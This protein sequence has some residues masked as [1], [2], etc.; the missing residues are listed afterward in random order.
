MYRKFLQVS[1]NWEN[2]EIVKKC[3]NQIVQE[4]REL[5][6]IVLTMEETEREELF[7]R[8]SKMERSRIINLA[9]KH[10]AQMMDLIHRYE[11]TENG[12]QRFIESLFKDVKLS[13]LTAFENVYRNMSKHSEIF[14][15]HLQ[16]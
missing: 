5:E 12:K 16:V 13:M 6:D 2:I 9:E 8:T 11:N 4:R 7:E 3:N 15:N 10:C 1:Q 14:E